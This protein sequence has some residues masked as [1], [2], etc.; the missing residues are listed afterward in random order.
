MKKLTEK[1]YEEFQKYKYNMIHGYIWTPDTLE[2]ICAGNEY[3][4]ERIGK[5]MLEMKV[6]LQNE[7]ISHMLSDK[8]KKYVIRSLRKDELELLKDFLYEAIYIPEGVKAPE[9]NIVEKP[10]LRVCTGQD[11]W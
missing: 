3:D 6:K 7:H 8:W 5:Q 9:K 11:F 4:P 1:E 10:E 2:M